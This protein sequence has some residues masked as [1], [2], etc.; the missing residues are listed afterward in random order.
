M[1]NRIEL[2]LER[3]YLSIA[4]K[5]LIQLRWCHLLRYLT[6]E[7]FV[8]EYL[9]RCGCDLPVERQGAARFPFGKLKVAH[10]FA[11]QLELVVVGDFNPSG[12]EG[13]IEISNDRWYA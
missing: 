11:S 10:F 2:D 4:L 8:L 7:N 1:V 5:V 3:L 6:H 9:V 13:T 12:I